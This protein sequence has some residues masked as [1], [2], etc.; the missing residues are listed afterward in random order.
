MALFS[1]SSKITV[2]ENILVKN[3]IKKIFY[4]ILD[5][6]NKNGSY[7]ISI[8][9]INKHT[10]KSNNDA[11]LI[12]LNIGS[13]GY[14]IEGFKDLDFSS[15]KYDLERSTKFIKYDLRKDPIPFKDNEV[16]NIYCSHVIEHIE[17]KHVDNFIKESSRVLKKGGVLRLVTPDREFLYE[18]LIKGGDYWRNNRITNWF[19]SRGIDLEK[20]DEIDF[21][22]REISTEKLR[23]FSEKNLKYYNEVK[24]NLH[25]YNYIFDILNQNSNWN[26]ENMGNHINSWD[27]EKI[28][29]F[30]QG[31][32]TSTIKSKCKGSIS[33]S[34]QGDAFDLTCPEMSIYVDLR[35]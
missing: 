34:M 19:Y 23:F 18:M 8:I 32:F 20:C 10:L 13:G 26:E 24:N 1:V 6:I 33:K 21:F 15:S 29:K 7:V 25:N 2:K 3:I 30:S 5:I 28:K 9:K 16:D 17:D 27:Y 14:N 31:Y 35:K 22:I 4:F 12:N 11:N